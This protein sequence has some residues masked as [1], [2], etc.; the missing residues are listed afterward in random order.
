[1]NEKPRIAIYYH[2]N[3]GR[4]DGA[5][6]YYFNLMKN[7][8]GLDITH[9]MPEGDISR[10]GKFDFHF[11]VDYGEDGLP[12]DRSWQIPNDGGK[13]IY[14]CSD[15]HI[16]EGG[17][18]YR[19]TKALDFDYVYF[20]QLRFLPEYAEFCKTSTKKPKANQQVWF[21][22]HAVEPT[23]YPKFEI[24]KKYDV[25]FIGHIQDVKNYNGFSRVDMLDRVFKEFPN[26]YFGSRNPIN[27]A[28]NMFEDAS[29]R[30]SE[31]K[32]CLNIS[33]KDDLNMR[34]FEALSSG[35]FQITN[36][37]PTLDLLFEDGKH[38]VTYKTL[39]DMVEKVK[40]YI[41]H[42]D[43]REKI[44]EAGHKRVLEVGTYRN[45]LEHIFT[46]VGFP[47]KVEAKPFLVDASIFQKQ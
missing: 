13:T 29:K 42:E 33:I 11:W 2:S 44:A 40:Y 5:P 20:N 22:P 26:F 14:I 19:F 9:L 27:P 32:I 21:L 17:R 15:A 45:R 6:L 7:Q 8:M 47:M 12:V 23:A 30:F 28:K 35:S 25:C 16:D 41:G 36:W 37:L 10:F 24:V 38:L 3:F 18:N 39:D 43:E 1:M 46:H 4:N 31:S 34:L